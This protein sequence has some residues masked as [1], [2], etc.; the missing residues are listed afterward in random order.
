MIYFPPAKINIGLYIG[1]VRP[2]GYHEILTAMAPVKGLCDVLEVLHDPEGEGEEF[3]ISGRP[4]GGNPDDNLVLR[5]CRLFRESYPAGKGR[6]RLLL[7]KNI[8]D[9]AGMG[10]GSSDAAYTL[11]ALNDLFYRP[12]GDEKLEEMAAK[13]GADCPFFIRGGAKLATGTGTELKDLDMPLAGLYIVVLKRDAAKVST[14]EAYASVEYRSEFPDLEKLLAPP[15]EEWRGKIAND[16]EAGVPG[17]VAD[18]SLLKLSLYNCGAVYASMTGSGAAVY[19]LF[20]DESSM[21]LAAER[22]HDIMVYAG[23]L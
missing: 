16:F 1:S 7:C 2:D 14:R 19:G 3:E 9:G 6:I 15:P 18:A 23:K 13:L 11:K 8:P 20:R 10:G 21:R 12:F 17:R 22:H 4:I 5:A